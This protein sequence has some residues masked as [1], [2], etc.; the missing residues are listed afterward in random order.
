[1]KIWSL[2]ISQQ[3]LRRIDAEKAKIAQWLKTEQFTNYFGFEI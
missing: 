3:L 2:K 1:M